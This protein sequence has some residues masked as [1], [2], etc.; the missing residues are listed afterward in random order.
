MAGYGHYRN[1]QASMNNWEPAYNAQFEISFT[2]PAGIADWDITLENVKKVGGLKTNFMPE[3]V[4]QTFKGATRSYVGGAVPQQTNDIT[5]DFE[6][7]LNDSNSL[8][9]YKALRAWS[10][11][12]YDPL[13]GKFGMK[14]DY[15]GGPIIISQFNKD[16]DIFQKSKELWCNRKQNNF[17]SDGLIFTSSFMRLILTL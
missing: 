17:Y 8:Y 5:L 4:T 15:I 14:K 10:D 13:T 6:L 3:L 2:P 16:G 7:N 11:L 12:I 1:S 9:V